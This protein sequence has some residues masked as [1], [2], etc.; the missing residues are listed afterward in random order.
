MYKVQNRT[1]PTVVLGWVLARTDGT[2]PSPF[3]S[4]PHFSQEGTNQLRVPSRS[5]NTAGAIL[6]IQ[7]IRTTTGKVVSVG[8][9]TERTAPLKK[10]FSK[11]FHIEKVCVF[12]VFPM[13][14]KS[15]KRHC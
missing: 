8:N 2:L 13:L 6:W 11:I 4:S 3:P 10:H 5:Y 1:V 9:Y 12:V 15:L 7:G 14:K